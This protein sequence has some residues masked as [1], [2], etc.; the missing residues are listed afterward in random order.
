MYIYDEDNPRYFYHRVGSYR[1]VC[2]VLEIIMYSQLYCA[3][4]I[5]W[6][7]C[8]TL[9]SWVKNYWLQKITYAKHNAHV[10]KGFLSLQFSSCT[11]FLG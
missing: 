4:A 3:F 10:N 11:E 1:Y 5:C 9:F 8:F 7:Y 6:G 2:A